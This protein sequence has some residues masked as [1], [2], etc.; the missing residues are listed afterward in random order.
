MRLALK[1]EDLQLGNKILDDLE[2][3]A[4]NMSEADSLGSFGGQVSASQKSGDSK[5]LLYDISLL[6]MELK[7][8]NSANADLKRYFQTKKFPINIQ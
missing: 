1:S 5:S 4:A 8:A 6:K 3:V 7:Q 2:Y